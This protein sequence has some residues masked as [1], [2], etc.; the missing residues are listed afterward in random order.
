MRTMIH[1][2]ICV[3]CLGAFDPDDAETRYMPH[4]YGDGVA[5]ERYSVCPY[6]GSAEILD[7]RED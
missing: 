3:E 7:F 5:Y 4:P 1:S 6:C 2:C